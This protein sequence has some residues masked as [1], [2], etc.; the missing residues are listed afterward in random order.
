M[1]YKLSPYCDSTPLCL[2]ERSNPTTVGNSYFK[3][4]ISVEMWYVVSYSVWIP[5]PD[6]LFMEP[7]Y[8]VRRASITC[9][10]K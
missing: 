10:R 8:G 9:L 6:L 3:V 7:P 2:L 4:G 1:A 5:N